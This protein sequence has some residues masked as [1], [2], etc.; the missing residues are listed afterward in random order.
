M[1]R[2]VPRL[3]E[4]QL[5]AQEARIGADLHLGGHTE[6]I[7]ELQRLCRAHPLREQLHALLMLAL[8]RD[9]RR[10]EALAAYQDAR[11]VL[12]EELGME[13]GPN[14]AACNSRSWPATTP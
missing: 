9:S 1:L 2:E 7:A 14:C 13:P 11:R 4:L 8:Y 5:Q 10:A 6:V 3:A 12:V